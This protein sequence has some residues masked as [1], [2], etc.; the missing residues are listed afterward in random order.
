MILPTMNAMAIEIKIPEII[1]SAF[2]LLMKSPSCSPVSVVHNVK[3]ATATAAPSSSNTSETVVEVGSPK[4]LNRS[5]RITSVSI[6]AR[7][8]IIIAGKVNFSG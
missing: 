5:S 1:A 2:P 6:T 7:N 4:V 8:R 3:S